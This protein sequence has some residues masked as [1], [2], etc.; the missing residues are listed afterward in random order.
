[1]AYLADC[2][3]EEDQKKG[4]SSI[5]S[6]DNQ[7]LKLLVLTVRTIEQDYTVLGSVWQII[8]LP[9]CFIC[10]KKNPKHEKKNKNHKTRT[11][12][13]KHP[14]TKQLNTTKQRAKQTPKN[15]NSPSP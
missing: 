1:M 3:L 14:Q 7:E 15:S 6:I 4:T 2:I 10:L 12:T 13:T 11:T 5:T 8:K 9:A